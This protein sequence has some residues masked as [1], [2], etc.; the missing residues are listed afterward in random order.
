[1]AA[2]AAVGFVAVGLGAEAPL[3]TLPASHPPVAI[4]I[5]IAVGFYLAEAAVVHLHIGRS[6]HSFSMSEIPL[7]VGFFFLSPVGL[8]AARFVGAGL[9]LMIA[10]RQ[11]SV[12]LAFNLSQFMLSSVAA[13]AVLHILIDAFPPTAAARPGIAATAIAPFGPAEWIAAIAA[14]LVENFVGVLAVA[15]AITLAEGTSQFRRVPEMMRDRGHRRDHQREP[16][17]ARGDGR[18]RPA[19]HRGAVRGTDRDRVLRLSRLYRPA[20]A[21]PRPRDALR[22]DADPPAQPTGG[23]RAALA[24]RPRPHHVPCRRRGDHAASDPPRRT[25]APHERRAGDDRR[26]D[27]ADR[28]RPRRCAASPR[29]RRPTGHARPGRRRRAPPRAADGQDTEPAEARQFRNAM[30]APLVGESRIVGTIVVANRLSD[31]ST[32]DRDELR[33]FATLASHT[34]IALENGQLE[35]S[36]AQLSELKEELHHQAFHDSLTGLANRS[37]FTERVAA[38]IAHPDPLGS[39]PVVLF[40]DLDDF[41]LVND[42]L[43]HAAGDALLRAVGERLR[44]GLRADDVAAR[45]GGDEFAILVSDTRNSPWPRTSRT[46]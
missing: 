36:L 4:F 35:Q 20:P 12:K 21:A 41:K 10:R 32:F 3:R 5:V 14:T 2:V 16:R 30:V 34:A 1:M 18:R 22:V 11:R 8:L 42:T 39:I 24:A 38:R 15:A 33:L 9:A 6:A 45:L 13:L 44:L 28:A 17:A 27:A 25:G 43:G 26:R 37:L 40:I 29:D 7:I 31:I 46:A 23:Q 19:G